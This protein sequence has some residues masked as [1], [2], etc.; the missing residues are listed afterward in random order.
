[1]TTRAESQDGHLGK[2]TPLGRY[3]VLGKE[4]IPR[5]GVGHTASL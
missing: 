1:M 5:Q 4:M 2:L 3:S